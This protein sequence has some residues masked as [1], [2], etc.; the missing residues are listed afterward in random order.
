M[1]RTGHLYPKDYW[2]SDCIIGNWMGG[3]VASYL[4]HY[5]T[6]YGSTPVRDIGL[7]ASE[8]RMTIPMRDGTPSGIL[9]VTTH[10]F[11]FIPEEEAD[12]KQPTV[13]GAHELKEGRAYFIL[14]TT[15]FGLYRYHIHDLV[16]VTGFHNQTPLIEF[17]SK[18]SHFAN[19]TGEKLSEYHVAGAMKDVQQALN[20][21]L[22]A[23]SLA[24]CWDDVAPYYGLFVERG[25]LADVTEG[26]RLAEALD[27]QLMVVNVEYG[28]KR[29]SRRLGPVRLELLPTS[30]WQQWDRARQARTGGTPEQYK[31]PCLI[32]DPKFRETVGVEEEVQV[33]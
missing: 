14:P 8:G 32:S 23:Y 15:A 6:Y 26:V 9:D 2:P 7:L 5:P 10:Y 25:D 4:R 33:A 29:R 18:G 11:E 31:H 27:R 17:L 12:S 30:T 3:S 1:R 16:R 21:T 22:T 24:P 19:I 13:V 28:E 20:L